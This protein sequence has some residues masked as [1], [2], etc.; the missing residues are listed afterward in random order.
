MREIIHVFGHKNPD[1]DSICSAIAYANLKNHIDPDNKYVASALGKPSKETLFA[2]EQAGVEA[3]TVIRHLKPQVLD[4]NLEQASVVRESTSIKTTLET[5]VS[6]VG[7]SIPV[8]GTHNHLIGVVSISDVLPLYMSM[9]GQNFLQQSFTPFK[10]LIEELS[11]KLIHGTRPSGL[12]L[13]RVVLL[14]DLKEHEILEEDDILFCDYRDYKK[15]QLR[16]IKV[17]HIILANGDDEP[18]EIHPEEKR[19]IF[20]GTQSL[21]SML[22]VLNQIAPIKSVVH[23]ENLEYFTTYE[24]LDDVK[25]NMLTSKFRRFPVVN[26]EGYIQ[27]MISKSNLLDVR[28]KK[29]ILV[30]H[31]EKGQSIDGIEQ[32]N[33]LEVIDH[34]RVADVQT[35]GPLYFRV[36]PVGCTCTIVAKMYY[37]HKIP[38]EKN[39]A[40]IMLSA[41]LSDTLIFNSPTCTEVDREMAE[42]LA[43]IAELDTQ[44]YGMALIH[45]G[46]DLSDAT[47]YK[48]VTTD[49]KRFMFGEYKV[50][51]AQTNTSDFDGF[52]MMYNEVKEEV[53]KLIEDESANLFV[54][55]VTDVLVGGTE[56]IAFGKD[57]WIAEQAFQIKSDEHSIFLPGVFSRKKQ[58]VPKLM[59][60]AHL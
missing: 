53:E 16:G 13:G 29:A 46:S 25:K 60:A 45:A 14:S 31:N 39:M 49:M 12:I 15:H 27:G 20:V 21:C 6:Q 37:E 42:R 9:E 43:I 40:K 24:T 10:N 38:I 48:V 52:F 1:T 30:D 36:E 34:H 35:M 4:L 22:K 17:G 19:D 51:I 55:L 2:L 57:K 58:V 33:L 18:I 11:L 54:L 32:V 47:P 50:M 41:I 59:Q 7:R 5:I 23:K 28:Q 44:Y 3:P 8:V 26:E 56:L